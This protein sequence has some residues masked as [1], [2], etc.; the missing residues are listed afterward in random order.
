MTAKLAPQVG[1]EFGCASI[2]EQIFDVKQVNAIRILEKRE[3]L[4]AFAGESCR[5]NLFFGFFFDG[6]KNNYVEAEKVKNHSNVAR[7]Y[8]CYPGAS[9]PGIVPADADWKHEPERY[10]HFFKVYVPGIASPFKQVGDPGDWT[11]GAAAAAFGE[12]RIIWALL[13]AINNLH[14]YFLKTPLISSQESDRL[15]R[16]ILLRADAR[17]LMERPSISGERRPFRSKDARYYFEDVLKRLHRALA[18][19]WPNKKTGKPAKIDPAIVK[20][21]Y[22]SIFGFSRGA[23][24]ARAFLNWFQSLCKLDAQM[25]GASVMS[26]GGFPVAFDFLGLFDTVASVGSANTYGIVDG[27]GAWA[28][29]ENSLRIPPGVKCLHLVAAHEL[30]RSFPV[31]SISVMGAVPDGCEEVV[32]PGVHSDIGCGY[33]PREQGR[34][35][36]PDG[37]D[38]LSRIPLIMMYKAARLSGVPLKL[39]LASP[40]AKERFACEAATINAFNSYIAECKTLRGPLHLIMREQAKKQLEWRLSR[41]TSGTNALGNT[42]S[43]RRASAYDQNDLHCAALEFEDELNSFVEWKGGKATW[44][45][46]VKTGLDEAQLHDWREISSWWEKLG[47]PS[48]EVA[49]FFDNYVHDSRAAFKMG[50]A[51]SQEKVRA[52]LTKWLKCINHAKDDRVARSSISG[53]GMTAL[54]IKAHDGLTDDQRRAAEEY[55]RTGKI[56]RM[57]NDGRESYL[58]AAAGY[59]RFRKIYRGFDSESDPAVAASNP[60]IKATG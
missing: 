41:R 36:H 31:D 52:N 28:D 44:V 55:G 5:T 14:R 38:M 12:R 29:A 11:V 20:T 33:S 3:Q 58:F 56:P 2:A 39:E 43:F 50:G 59:L 49:D 60:R 17:R 27:H 6:T 53:K 45:R 37:A 21:V 8:D 7:L 42:E 4:G 32:V 47:Q 19:H 10:R 51:D 13:Q 54:D 16:L 57:I 18:A 24:E 35:V 30:R 9:V 46:A 23:T 40:I 1:R 26:L 25:V 22:I 34:G 15:I 48:G